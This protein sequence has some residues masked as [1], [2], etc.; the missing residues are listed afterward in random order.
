MVYIP[1]DNLVL[2][3]HPFDGFIDYRSVVATAED[4]RPMVKV[5]AAKI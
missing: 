5:D 4:F 2:L 3:H 1:S